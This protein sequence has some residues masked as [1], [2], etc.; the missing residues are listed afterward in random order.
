MINYVIVT[1]VA[2]VQL[3]A[4][5]LIFMAVGET[6]SSV[7]MTMAI[8]VLGVS[9][10]IHHL[11]V[12]N[13]FLRVPVNMRKRMGGGGWNTFYCQCMDVVITLIA[14]TW[15]LYIGYTL[16]LS[17]AIAAY[18][19]LSNMIIERLIAECNRKMLKNVGAGRLISI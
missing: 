4:A 7:I 19:L 6:A 13:F 18:L 2:L 14:T 8:V 10:R 12:R 9:D 17:V 1:M 15:L 16:Y 5:M 11:E 3:L